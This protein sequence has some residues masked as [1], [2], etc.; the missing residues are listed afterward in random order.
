MVLMLG[1]FFCGIQQVSTATTEVT[2]V[3]ASV[4]TGALRGRAM[5][6]RQSTCNPGADTPRYMHRN[7]RREHSFRRARNRLLTQSVTR[8][9]GAFI[10][11]ER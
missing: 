2:V 8:Y 6:G 11:R 7:L 3:G 5:S 4:P 10:M 1:L 9:R